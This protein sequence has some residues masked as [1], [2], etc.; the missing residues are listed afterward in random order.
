MGDPLAC[1]HQ[2]EGAD[3]VGC[4]G[5]PA[6]RWQGAEHVGGGRYGYEAHAIQELVE[7]G[8]V[9]T[10]VVVQ[11]DPADHD[12]A[13]GGQLLPRDDVGVVLEG[14]EEDDVALG[15]V[16]PTPRMGHQVD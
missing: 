2:A 10:A 3:G 12:T 14:R 8:Q 5:D 13:F 6:N 1:V 16:C 9:Q 11:G 15:E 4:V 7:M